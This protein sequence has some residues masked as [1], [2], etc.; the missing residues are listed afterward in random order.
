MNSNLLAG[1]YL[2]L[3][4]AVGKIIESKHSKGDKR[5][6]LGYNPSSMSFKGWL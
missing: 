4:S 1:L 2:L 5:F 3:L 6:K